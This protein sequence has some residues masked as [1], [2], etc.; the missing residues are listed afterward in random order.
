MLPL[1]KGFAYKPHQITG[2]SWMLEREE[3]PESGGLLCDEMGLGKT[4]EVLGVMANSSKKFTLLL[5]PKAVISQW[6]EAASKSGFNVFI[7]EDCE[8]LLNDESYF[9]ERVKEALEALVE[10]AGRAAGRASASE[11]VTAN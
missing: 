1:W 9:E 10:A 7:I 3:K 4:M 11:H 2:I 5:C 8:K 6:V